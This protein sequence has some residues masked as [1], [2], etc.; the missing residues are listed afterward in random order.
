KLIEIHFYFCFVCCPRKIYSLACFL[1]LPFLSLEFRSRFGFSHLRFIS[2]LRFSPT[3]LL[4]LNI[5]LLA[6]LIIPLCGK[7]LKLNKK[8]LLNAISRVLMSFLSSQRFAPGRPTFLHCF[9]FSPTML[10]VEW[11][12]GWFD[13]RVAL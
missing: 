12:L 11:H 10:C 8:T 9:Y 13:R 3:C 2:F 5:C 1:L 7:D 4:L 6:I